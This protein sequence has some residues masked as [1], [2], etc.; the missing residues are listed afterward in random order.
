MNNL[1]SIIVIMQV[2][3]AVYPLSTIQTM[4]LATGW[5]I[6]LLVVMLSFVNFTCKCI[7]YYLESL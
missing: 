4:S 2:T 3:D 5:F 1:S 6:F 7:F